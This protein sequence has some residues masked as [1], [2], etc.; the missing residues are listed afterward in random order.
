MPDALPHYFLPQWITPCDESLDVDLCIYGGTSAG[1]AAACVAA[2]RGLSVVLLHPGQR[3]TLGGLTTNGLGYTDFGNQAAI[4]GWSRRFYK[5][6]GEKYG[7][8][9]EW[10]FEPHVADAVFR[11]LLAAADVDVRM[12]QFLQAAEVDDGRIAALRML[13]GMRVR[14]KMFVDA[15]YEGD[16]MAAAGVSYATGRESNRQ[17]GETLNGAQVMPTHQFSHFVDPFVTPGD[18]SSGT[19]PGIVQRD[20][21]PAG[22]GDGSVQ[23]YCFRV[24]MTDDPARRV[25]FP[26]PED[27]DPLD[28][29][30]LRRWLNAEH[31]DY[32][33]TL[34]PAGDGGADRPWL[35]KVDRLAD[36]HKTDT[37]NH[38]PMSSDYIGMNHAWPEATYS[39]RENIFQAHVRYQQGLYWTLANDPAIP[40]R[41]R[42]VYG[43]FG[44][45]SDEF[46][47]TAHWPAQLYIREAR[48]LVGDYVVTE[49][50]CMGH[51]SCNDPVALGAYAMDSHNCNRVIRADESGRVRVLNEGDVQV[52]LP[53]PY[54]ISYRSIVPRRGE[55]GNLLVPVCVSASHIAFG[56]AR[57]EPVFMILGESAAL[58]A[59]L[60]IREGVAVQDMAYAS[61]R[62]EL[63]NAGQVLEAGA[64]AGSGNP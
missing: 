36:P 13:G 11:D 63:E 62:R 3:T 42:E 60:A 32:N 58:A 31:D 16:L 4:G 6:L 44:L 56:S 14:A 41:Y 61:L 5:R 54:A 17:Y 29:E 34:R 64:N 1:I 48:R 21:P 57:M 25:A 27:Y 38:G 52:K 24:C 20:A 26:K 9:E 15:T 18:P 23:A 53:S 33:E 37:N 28:Y 59:S 46:A 8:E 10:K 19:L 35:R 22:S 55:V 45:A 43:K 39:Q 49:H 50:D 51:A 12:S 40:D 47:S 30:L 2:D 7:R